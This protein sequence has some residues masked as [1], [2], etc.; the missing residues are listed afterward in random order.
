MS[1]CKVGGAVT[2]GRRLSWH[3]HLLYEHVCMVVCVWA[4][5]EMWIIVS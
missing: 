4:F 2:E 5:E 1:V 3:E